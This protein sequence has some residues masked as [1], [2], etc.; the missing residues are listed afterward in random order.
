VSWEI[1][2]CVVKT[3]EALS[4]WISVSCEIDDFSVQRK[5]CGSLIRLPQFLRQNHRFLRTQRSI[6][7]RLP[8]FLRQTHRFVS[9]EIDEFVVKT[10][11][12][13]SWWISVSCEIDDFNVQRKT[14]GSLILLNLCVLKNR[15]FCRKNCGHIR[16]IYKIKNNR[17]IIGINKLKGTFFAYTSRPVWM[18]FEGLWS[19]NAVI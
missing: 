4:C 14:C 19:S 2:D 10:V 7:I 6:R 12:V 13:L 8:Q 15:W 5:T 16:W 11:E 9:W 1:D 17:S 18:G 3:V